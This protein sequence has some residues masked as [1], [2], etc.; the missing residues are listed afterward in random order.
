MATKV[1]TSPR[2]GNSTTTSTPLHPTHHDLSERARRRVI[3]LLNQELADLFDLAS[4]V[5]QAHWNVK[6]PQFMALHQLFDKVHHE[7][8]EAIDEVAE[9]AVQ[10]GGTA[11]GTAR[12]AAEHSRLEEY[13]H[14]ITEG[15]D[16]VEA[17]S[18]AIA[19]CAKSVRSAI[20]SC[21]DCGDAGSADLFTEVSR[22]LDKMLWMVEAHNQRS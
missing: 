12:L 15:H 2:T 14:T 7:V 11:M 16:H 22:E 13:P 4:Q 20:E 8:S 10:L 19:H 21:E 18:A 6:G 1:H 9:R 5:K 3:D 17:V